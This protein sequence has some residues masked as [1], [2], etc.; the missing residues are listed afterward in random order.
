LLR[1]VHRLRL[2]GIHLGSMLFRD[3]QTRKAS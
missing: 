1:R 3:D 2:R